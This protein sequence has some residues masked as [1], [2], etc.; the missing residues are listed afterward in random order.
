MINV[1]K[2]EAPYRFV[3]RFYNG[4]WL[5]DNPKARGKGQKAKWTKVEGSPFPL[6]ALD[7]DY[8]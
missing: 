4:G 2:Y 1:L 5:V 7:P 8:I 6:P 3:G